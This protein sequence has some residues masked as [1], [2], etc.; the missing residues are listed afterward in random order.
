MK[1]L[2]KK[3][4]LLRAHAWDDVNCIGAFL[5][6]CAFFVFL[7]IMSAIILLVGVVIVAFDYCFSAVMTLLSL[8]DGSR[9]KFVDESV[10]LD[11]GTLGERS[12]EK[13]KATHAL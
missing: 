7:L 8:C 10:L 9:A 1:T 13:R 6:D 4:S 2:Y 5:L 3:A 12:P 11:D